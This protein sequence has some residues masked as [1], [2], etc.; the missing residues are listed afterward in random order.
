MLMLWS[1]STLLGRRKTV[2]SHR[3]RLDGGNST[4]VIDHGMLYKDFT[5]TW[6]NLCFPYE[7]VLKPRQR[8]K[9]KRHR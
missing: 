6:E 3:N 1:K 5:G 9:R 7:K 8:G 2:T 4:G